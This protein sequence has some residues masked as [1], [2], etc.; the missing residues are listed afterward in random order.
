MIFMITTDRLL[1]VADA[2]SCNGEVATL[3]AVCELGH[4]LTEVTLCTEHQAHCVTCW[5]LFS[6]AVSLIVTRRP[7]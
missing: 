1:C 4:H 5:D 6:L 2:A 7:A 3:T